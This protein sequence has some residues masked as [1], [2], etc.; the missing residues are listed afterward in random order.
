MSLRCPTRNCSPSPS[1]C[2]RPRSSASLRRALRQHAT[3]LARDDAGWRA[4]IVHLRSEVTSELPPCAVRPQ[5]RW[6]TQ[7]GQGACLRC[8]QVVTHDGL[9]SEAWQ[10]AAD[11]A[12]TP[13]A[14]E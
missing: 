14:L 4:K 8:P 1:L 7:E 9:R 13:E 3:T 10:K 5:C 6:W 11:P 12:I 2:N